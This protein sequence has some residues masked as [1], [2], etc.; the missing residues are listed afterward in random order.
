MDAY[1]LQCPLHYRFKQKWVVSSGLHNRWD[2]DLA[3][4]SNITSENEG[5]RYLLTAINVLTSYMWV[6]PLRNKKAWIIQTLEKIFSQAT[7]PKTIRSDKEVDYNN[8]HVEDFLES[9]EITYY[10]TQNETKAFHAERVIRTLDTT[11]YRYFTY[12]QIYHYLYIFQDLVNDYNHR[13]HRSLNE[14]S[15]KDINKNNEALVLKEQYIDS[16]KKHI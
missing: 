14:R 16:L 11:M 7:L 10:V 6:E 13:P 1:S 2:I 3:D 4:V 9:N 8:K 5:I 15:P 12:K